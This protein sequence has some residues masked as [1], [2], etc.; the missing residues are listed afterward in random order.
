MKVKINLLINELFTWKVPT[1]GCNGK[2]VTPGDCSS[3]QSLGST[4][5]LNAV[6]FCVV[7]GVWWPCR[8]TKKIKRIIANE[9]FIYYK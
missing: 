6:N 2:P 4:T 7:Y 3:V 8:T 5:K 9:M 1:S